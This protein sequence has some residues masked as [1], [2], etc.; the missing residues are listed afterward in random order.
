MLSEKYPGYGKWDRYVVMGGLWGSEIN[1]RPEWEEGIISVKIGSQ[2]VQG[3][4]S[5]DADV[6]PT[7]PWVFEKKG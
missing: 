1:L 7:R 3:G 5:A 4:R 2:E 6:H